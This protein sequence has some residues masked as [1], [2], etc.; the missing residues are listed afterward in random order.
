VC[1]VNQLLFSAA[2]IDVDTQVGERQKI[3]SSVFDYPGID[4]R[5]FIDAVVE[6]TRVEKY[7]VTPLG[8]ELIETAPRLIWHQGEPFGSTTIYSQWH[9]MQLARSAG[10]TVLLDGQGA[11]ELVAGYAHYYSSFWAEL[12]RTGRIATLWRE[13]RTFPY[14]LETRPGRNLSSALR[15]LALHLTRRE[16]LR[17][18]AFLPAWLNPQVARGRTLERRGHHHYASVLDQHLYNSLTCASLPS[19][20]HY[21]D[22][23]SMAF[24]IEARVPYLDYRL[25]E[26]CYSLPTHLKI[27]KGTTKVIL[28]QAMRGIIPEI[29][30]TRQDKLGFP[31]PGD[32]WFREQVAKDVEQIFHSRRFRERGYVRPEQSLVLLERHQRGAA[33]VDRLLWRMVCFELWMRTFFD[34]DPTV[35]P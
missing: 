1:I 26:L 19:L 9:V 23:N 21:E 34:N 18:G 24:S 7:A 22:H 11:D 5:A 20:L 16:R 27:D 6:Q 8:E 31:T 30:R 25:V 33:K 12:I 10:I 35:C 28:R 15:K 2:G 3:F 17:S 29:V 4:E 14:H 32:V 13:W